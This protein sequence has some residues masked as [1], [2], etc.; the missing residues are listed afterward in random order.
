[1]DFIHTLDLK[2]QKII[3]KESQT[4]KKEKKTIIFFVN[5]LEFFF[6]HRLD[7]AIEAEK[8]FK[9]VIVH[10]IMASKSIYINFSEIY[11]KYN[12]D[13]VELPFKSSQPNLLLDLKSIYFLLR[14]IC[15]VN[16]T[17]IHCIGMRASTCLFLLSPFLSKS[18]FI[19]SIT[20]LGPFFAD[21][22][23][24]KKKIS[25]YFFKKLFYILV[26]FTVKKHIST[27]IVQN[28]FDKNFFSNFLKPHFRAKVIFI[29][30]S[31]CNI[32]NILTYKARKKNIVL[33]PARILIDK[34]IIE[35][36]QAATILKKIFPNW[37]FYAAGASDYISSNSISIKYLS[38]YVPNNCVKFLGH[39]SDIDKLFSISSIV[40]LPSYREGAP[41]ALIEASA[42]G[43]AI[44]TSN[45]PGCQ[46]IITD[47][48]T[49]KLVSEKSYMDLY[50]ALL[51]LISNRHLIR[52]YGSNARRLALKKFDI[53]LVVR[54]HM[55][56]YLYYAK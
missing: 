30:G 13:Y 19:F 44:V 53:K 33:F 48:I 5:S 46:D 22:N 43:C 21:S 23:T 34:G 17:I 42:H 8:N 28:R 39:V 1:M 49:G 18:N 38:D 25:N 37:H 56:M 24:L 2:T 52:K 51:V 4:L 14:L 35:F 15:R 16:P 6:S 40:C 47:G 7:I 10:G 55:K 31:G 45:V 20:G 41:K 50:N 11:Q 54:T 12:F 9:I 36:C 26:N 3:K 27:F 32:N 29:L